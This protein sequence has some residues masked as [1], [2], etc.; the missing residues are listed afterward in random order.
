MLDF[1]IDIIDET[2]EGWV[3]N[4]RNPSEKLSIRAIF[5]HHKAR[6]TPVDLDRHDVYTAHGVLTCG[7]S[8]PVPNESI[9]WLEICVLSENGDKII[10]YDKPVFKKIKKYITGLDN[11]CFLDN[12]TNSVRNLLVAGRPASHNEIEN[13][14]YHIN[15]I[16][17]KLS[18]LGIKL[19][20]IIIPEKNHILSDLDPSIEEISKNRIAS[21]L[22]DNKLDNYHYLCDILLSMPLDMR[23]SF[24]TK[25]DQHLNDT[26]IN[27]ILNYLKTSVFREFT[28]LPVFLSNQN[29]D[30]TGKS[31]NLLKVIIPKNAILIDKTEEI[32]ENGGRLT[33][34]TIS[35]HNPSIVNTDSVCLLGTSSARMFLYCLS[36]SYRDITHLWGSS[37]KIDDIVN[38]QARECVA[39]LPERFIYGHTLPNLIKFNN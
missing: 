29:G 11:Y 34:S 32:I 8:I 27:F 2:I 21:I 7:F 19:N 18:E 37:F 14:I 4:M 35:S 16:T 33:G 10:Y 3:F 15:R 28:C 36:G 25:N 6:I 1:Y 24:F 5:N 9:D 31:E 12:D 17:S 13:N 38:S 23:S 30:L 26:G 39:L 22:N 20:I